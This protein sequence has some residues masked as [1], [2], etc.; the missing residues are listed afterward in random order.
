MDSAFVSNMADALISQPLLVA[1]FES[2]KEASFKEFLLNPHRRLPKL[3]ETDDES[4][5]NLH[6]GSLYIVKSGGL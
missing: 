4:E 3:I 2:D 6:N 1:Y 5:S